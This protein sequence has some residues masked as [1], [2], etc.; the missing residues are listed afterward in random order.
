VIFARIIPRS[1]LK[2]IFTL[3]QDLDDE[4]LYYMKRLYKWQTGKE[5]RK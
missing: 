3:R 2:Y 5:Y 1:I 4:I